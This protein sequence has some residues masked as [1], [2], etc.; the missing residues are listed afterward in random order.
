MISDMNQLCILTYLSRSGSTFLARLLSEYR[1]IGVSLEAEFPDGVCYRELVIH[2]PEEVDG[3]VAALGRMEMF[4]HWQID[5]GRLSARLRQMAFP[6]R[7][8]ALFQLILEMNF[9][10]DSAWI[11]LYKNGAYLERMEA[12]RRAFPEAKVLFITRDLRA[13]YN[14]QKR[15]I[16]GFGRRMGTSPVK[17]GL[18]YVR[19]ARLV[20]QYRDEPW[21]H[22]LRY[23][24]LLTDQEA[25]IGRV[26]EFLGAS[27]QK[28]AAEN[29]AEQI[30]DPQ[31]H[32]HVNVGQGA[33][34]SRIDGWKTELTTGEIETLQRVGREALAMYGYEALATELPAWKREAVYARDWSR[35]LPTTL[36][37][38][39]RRF[40]RR[41][42]WPEEAT[43]AGS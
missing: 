21:F 19:T 4:R 10:E 39:I 9:A 37:I 8:P 29:Y 36:P 11:H 27:P 22:L 24:D 31:K 41:T 42:G 12:A 16:D 23:E 15:T 2:G 1:D 38:L 14:S 6:I 33:R 35:F 25:E 13:I 3:A 5:P 20:A 43:T 34:T 40:R 17:C 30:P 18:Q 7:F 26:L 28:G 32:L